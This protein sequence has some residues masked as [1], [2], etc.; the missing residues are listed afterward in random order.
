MKYVFD[1]HDLC[2]ELYLSKFNRHDAFLKGLYWL[3]KNQF[4]TADAVI[5][6]NESYKEVAIKRGGKKPECPAARMPG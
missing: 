4:E 1:D 3:E 2:P 5:A 6:T